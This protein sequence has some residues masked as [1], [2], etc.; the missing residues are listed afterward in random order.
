MERSVIFNQGPNEG[1]GAI[2]FRLGVLDTF[3]GALKMFAREPESCSWG[4]L[5]P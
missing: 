5:K 1:E 4:V 3:G 2:I